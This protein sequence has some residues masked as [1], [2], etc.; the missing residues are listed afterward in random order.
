MDIENNKDLI[1]VYLAP[2]ESTANMIAGLLQ[3]EGIEAMPVTAATTWGT[4]YAVADEVVKLQK[5]YWGDVVVAEADVMRSLEL[6]RAYAPEE[7][8]ETPQPEVATSGVSSLTIRTLL[9]LFSLAFCFSAY[10][11]YTKQTQAL[12][13]TCF[14]C[15]VC[16]VFIGN[17]LPRLQKRVT[18]PY[19]SA[20]LQA[21]DIL[22]AA[23]FVFTLQLL[24]TVLL[25]G[26]RS[27][28]TGIGIVGALA[29]G[30][31]ALREI[32]DTT[33]K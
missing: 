21:S 30:Y 5:K 6:I 7:T 4:R 32:K 17:S 14:F 27:L 18:R 28:V 2:D 8:E 10:F 3:S 29:L 9:A 16:G 26:L 12:T 15:G 19:Q 11:S 25:D 31:S 23:A 20:V 13:F 33:A 22:Y 24:G 1:V